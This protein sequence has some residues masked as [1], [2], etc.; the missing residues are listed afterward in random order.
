MNSWVIHVYNYQ[1]RD[2]QGKMEQFFQYPINS[3]IVKTHL[4]LIIESIFPELQSKA[5]SINF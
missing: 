4:K 1:H 2:A 5:E 3:S